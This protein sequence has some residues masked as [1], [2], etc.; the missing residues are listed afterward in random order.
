MILK[1]DNLNVRGKSFPTWM[2]VQSSP[3]T[4]AVFLNNILKKKFP[5]YSFLHSKW[6]S[7][8]FQKI[9]KENLD[10]IILEI[11]TLTE[12][13]LSIYDKFNKFYKATP[14]ILVITPKAYQWLS[15]RRRDALD[16]SLVV[17]SEIKSL[18]YILQLPRFIEE[19][20]RKRRLRF[21]N[22]RLQRLVEKRIPHLHSFRSTLQ[23]AEGIN[24]RDMIE[25]LLADDKQNNRAHQCGLKLKITSWKRLRNSLGATAQNEL[26]DLLSRLINGIVRNSDRVLRSADDEFLIFLSNTQSSNLSRCKDRLE[27]ALRSFR[28][29]ANNRNLKLPIEIAAIDHLSYLT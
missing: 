6:A 7:E 21:Q 14:K 4:K 8:S 25:D 18:D 28:I 12:A 27:K 13:S 2:V 5:G 19:V 20:G 3:S 24:S 16:H 29:E 1:V 26:A 10:G 23:E 11:K 9:V 15:V 17:L 22:E